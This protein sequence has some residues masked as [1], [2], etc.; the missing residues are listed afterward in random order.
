MGK[1][2]KLCELEI[3]WLNGGES[4]DPELRQAILDARSKI[5]DI[6]NNGQIDAYN[7]I[8]DVLGIDIPDERIYCDDIAYIRLFNSAWT[9]E[10]KRQGWNV[11]VI[12]EIIYSEEYRRKH[13]WTSIFKKNVYELVVITIDKF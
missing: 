13:E 2:E 1:V 10:L 5:C 12:S 6:V 9:C 7:D 11:R 8:V 4:K 3:R